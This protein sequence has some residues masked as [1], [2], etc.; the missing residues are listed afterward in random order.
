MMK[1]KQYRLLSGLKHP[2]LVFGIG[3]LLCCGV[4]LDSTR[5]LAK[6]DL[7]K[8]AQSST[9]TRDNAKQLLNEAI[10]FYNQGTAKSLQ[11]AIKKAEEALSLYDSLNDK[12]SYSFV[13]F[14]I[15]RVYSDLGENQTALDYYEKVQPLF[16]QLGERGAEANTLNNIG[17]IYHNLGQTKKA[18]Y[19][20]EKALPLHPAL[21]NYQ[22]TTLNADTLAD[23]VRKRGGKA[24]TLNNIGLVYLVYDALGEKQKALEYF[25]QALPILRA[26]GDRSG[27]ATNLNNIGHVY[28][29]LGEKQ[30]ALDYFN[31]ALSIRPAV[32]DRLG[33]ATTLNNIGHVYFYLG[34]KQKALDYFNQALTLIKEVGYR[35][36]EATILKNIGILYRDIRRPIEA[37]KNL[38]KSVDII[39]QLRSSLIRENRKTFL[40]SQS[41][42]AV[43]LVNLL[44]DQKQPEK[45]FAWVNLATVADLADYS[46][47]VNAQVANPKAQAAIKQWN[48]ENQELENLRKQLSQQFSPE[49]SQQVNTLQEQLNQEAENIRNRFVEVADLFETKP[50]DI[51]QLQ[52]NITPGTTVIQ[53]VLLDKNIALFMLT[54][55]KVKVIKFPLDNQKF[56]S[57]LTNT[58]TSLTNRFS[59][60]YRNSS[61]PLYDLLIRP[62]EREIAA[63]KPKQISIIATGKLRYIP[64]EVLH[65][66]NEYLIEKYPISYLT[67]LSSRSLQTKPSTSNQKILAFG[68]PIPQ[69]PLALNGAEDEVKSIISIFPDS[70]I[71]INNQATLANF[72]NQIPRF[73]LLHLA[74]HGCFQK[75]GC[76]QLKLKE[77]TLLFADESFNIQDAAVLGLKNVDLITLSGCQTALKADSN[78]TEISGLAYLFE[79]AGSKAVIASLWSAADEETKEIMVE[80]YQNL[81]K[82]MRKDEALRQA[83]LSQIKN[84]VHPYFWSPFVLIGDGR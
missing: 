36:G 4:C 33:E 67:R 71:F 17:T 68:N 58:Y 41:D 32:R 34:E 62:I 23:A 46:R 63:T 24:A 44:I 59:T 73:S 49:L 80:F 31:Q 27:E 13:L 20:Y 38:E 45:A 61:Q 26:V 57:L 52:A 60:N 79:R 40:D 56:D 74:T 53:P 76:S 30:K 5:V 64:F 50:E 42:T 72:K 1:N 51:L 11:Q 3:I 65:D 82:G 35:S 75:G 70:Q 12:E 66:G 22:E 19:Y 37:I 25:N 21:N 10:K 39:L 47:L 69:P 16:H 48:Q 7:G 55:D 54:K 8:I 18:L 84:N 2:Y 6:D 15:G 43:S 28:F 83:K 14:A 29:Y 78:G 81:K 9:A 77:N